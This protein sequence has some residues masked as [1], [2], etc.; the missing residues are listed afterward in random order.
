MEENKLKGSLTIVGTGISVLGQTTIEARAHMQQAD[1][2]LYLVA[3]PAATHWIEGL[4]STAESLQ[5]FYGEGKRR[6]VTY[7]E[8]V[9][10]ILFYV[11]EGKRVCVAFYGHPGVFV[12]PAH[13]SIKQARS[14]GFTAKMLPGI[15]AEDCLFADLGV[16]PGSDGC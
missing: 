15:S 12:F 1:K 10:H 9:E 6:I 5:G 13:E 11:R 4:N 3:D 7:L 2:L 16:D 14:E 8:M